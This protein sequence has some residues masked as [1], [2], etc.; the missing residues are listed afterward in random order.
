VRRKDFP[1]TQFASIRRHGLE[2]PVLSAFIPVTSLFLCVSAALR[3][4]LLLRAVKFLAK[5]V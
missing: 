5:A 3:Y 1:T 4:N 2:A